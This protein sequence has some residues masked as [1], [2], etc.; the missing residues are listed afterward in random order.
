[1]MPAPR[2]G[3]RVGSVVRCGPP[4]GWPRNRGGIGT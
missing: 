2:P 4:T 1:M 3:A